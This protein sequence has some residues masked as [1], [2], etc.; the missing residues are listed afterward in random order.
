MS[1]WVEWLV[2][3]NYKDSLNSS[4]RIE[5]AL[6]SVPTL[7]SRLISE[8]R[9]IR[10]HQYESTALDAEGIALKAQLKQLHRWSWPIREISSMIDTQQRSIHTKDKPHDE[11]KSALWSNH[12]RNFLPGLF[13]AIACL[14][15]FCNPANSNR[16][17]FGLQGIGA[18]VD[19]SGWDEIAGIS[20]V[21]D[22]TKTVKTLIRRLL[23][24]VRIA[25]DHSYSSSYS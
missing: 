5:W 16:M 3:M 24:N 17:P 6:T 20:P 21:L 2:V 22:E 12:I 4:E 7:P 8:Q 11:W 25:R 9:G 18:L 10:P 19:E 23:K 13:S 1:D 14:Q 15:G